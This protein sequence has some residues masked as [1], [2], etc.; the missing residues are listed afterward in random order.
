VSASNF[1]NGG[2]NGS[3]T[4]NELAEKMTLQANVGEGRIGFS[5]PIA[6]AAANDVSLTGHRTPNLPLVGEEVT[7]RFTVANSGPAPSGRIVVSHTLSPGLVFKSATASQGSCAHEAGIVVCS[8]GTLDPAA[9]ATAT[10]IAEAIQPGTA[11][12]RAVLLLDSPDAFAANN[13]SVLEH[14][15]NLPTAIAPFSSSVVEGNAGATSMVFRLRLQPVCRL[16]V[17]LNFGTEDLLAL[18]GIDYVATNGTVVFPP[19]STNAEVAVVILGDRLDEGIESFNLRLSSPTNAVLLLAAS[20][21]GILNDDP[22]P[23]SSVDHFTVTE[24]GPG[25][26]TNVVFNVSLSAPSALPIEVTYRTSGGTAVQQDGGAELRPATLGSDYEPVSGSLLFS[27]GTTSQTVTVAIN[28]DRFYEPTETFALVL[29]DPV[30]ARIA[31]GAGVVTILDDDAGAIDHFEWSFIRSPQFVNE[32]FAATITAL[33]AQN[34]VVASFTGEASLRG[35][36]RTGEITIGNETNAWQFPLATLFH[37]ART[38][39]IY[40]ADEMGGAGALNGLSLFVLATPGQT[41]SNWTIRLRHTPGAGYG[42]P[43]WEA[44]AWTTVYQRD[45]TIRTDGWVNFPFDQPFIYD[46]TN[47]LMVDF[48]YDNATYTEDGL[49]ACSETA[50]R[51]TVFFQTDSAFGDPLNWTGSASPP[52]SLTNRAP[53]IRWS[54]ESPITITP[55]NTGRFVEGV[56]TGAIVVLNAASKVLLRATGPDDVIGVGNAFSAEHKGDSNDNGLPDGW[57]LRFFGL[58][59]P[60]GA[61]ADDDPDADG[62][63]NLQ[64]LLAGTHPLNP[65]SVFS[66]VRLELREGNAYLRFDTVSGRLY[67]VEFTVDLSNPDWRPVTGP[68]QGKGETME[69]VAGKVTQEQSRFYRVSLLP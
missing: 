12:A 49:C 18:A 61:G 48:S 24:G 14:P 6:I 63:T 32:P 41:L 4:V 15:V 55:T 10:V 46:G 44:G 11:S 35:L 33:D 13:E 30:N 67:R 40:L 21:G 16:P 17:S 52:P 8:L 68:L 5:A 19:G 50:E 62:Q 42:T 53:N 9:A 54:F 34:N 26:Q 22:A 2:W 3:V 58:L 37:D 51:R 43:A 7:Y 45:E 20:R 36:A 28:G 27:P 57:E 31:E 56:W 64:E 60:R 66:L 25:T 29:A 65:S 47:H 1:V 59:Y 39:V 69:V 23:S 38:Q